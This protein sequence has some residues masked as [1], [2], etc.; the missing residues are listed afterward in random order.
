MIKSDVCCALELIYIIGFG[1][2]IINYT[3]WYI[4]FEIF[5]SEWTKTGHYVDLTL[6][7]SIS[8]ET[9]LPR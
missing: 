6:S 8:F 5:F 2:K 7:Q 9:A 1:Y 3:D 4:F